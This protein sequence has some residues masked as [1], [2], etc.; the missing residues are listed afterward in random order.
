MDEVITPDLAAVIYSHLRA[1]LIDKARPATSDPRQ[2]DFSATST[3]VDEES[4]SPSVKEIS[5]GFTTRQAE[6]PEAT[7]LTKLDR[8]Y[9]HRV[10]YVLGNEEMHVRKGRSIWRWLVLKVFLFMRENSR[11]KIQNL[12]IPNDRLVEIGFVKDI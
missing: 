8:A 7:S 2:G 4:A 10:L 12:K 9:N 5:V 11:G 6:V 1:Y 3:V